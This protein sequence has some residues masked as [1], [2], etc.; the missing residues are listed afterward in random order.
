MLK[1]AKAYLIDLDGTLFRGHTPLEGA[2][3]WIAHLKQNHIPFLY[4]T[5][6]STRTPRALSDHLQS[7]GFMATPDDVYTS[8]LA[9]RD[10]LV[11]QYTTES[12][13]H[14]VCVIGE[15]GINHA[16]QDYFT[17]SAQE[18]NS[19]EEKTSL[20]VVG[21]DRHVTY[22]KVQRAV[23]AIIDGATFYA[24]NPD[25][26]LWTDEGL[27]PGAG[28]IVAWVAYAVDREPIMIGKPQPSFV[29]QACQ[30]L[31]VKASDTIVVGD[32]PRTDIRAGKAAGAYTVLLR[33]TLSQDLGD[34]IPDK[35]V[36]SLFELFA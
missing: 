4:W 30:R 17:I 15:E 14:V 2:I 33:S 12:K 28:S 10:H 7:I 29:H 22:Q 31:G 32:N 36:D 19:K 35:T 34:D 11:Q 20:V 27:A 25:R 16:L 26:L 23:K 21:L 8:S 1:E 5:N 3:E 13:Q 9:M 18:M 24:T 6:N